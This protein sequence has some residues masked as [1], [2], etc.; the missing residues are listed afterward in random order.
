MLPE[1]VFDELLGSFSFS[2]PADGGPYASYEA[3]PQPGAMDEENT[4]VELA[5]QVD[6]L[7][8]PYQE[9]IRQ[10][11]SQHLREPTGLMMEFETKVV[12]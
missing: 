11:S 5:I 12:D 2:K 9:R 3:V 6:Y 4:F 1:N 10:Q 8:S 7:D